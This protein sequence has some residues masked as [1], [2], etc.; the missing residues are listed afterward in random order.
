MNVSLYNEIFKIF[1]PGKIIAGAS[2]PILQNLNHPFFKK[3]IH[4]T[5]QSVLI[6]N[7]STFTYEYVS[8]SILNLTGHP[9]SEF[10]TKGL[11]FGFSLMHADDVHDLQTIVFPE[12][13]RCLSELSYDQKSRF[14]LSYTYRLQKAMGNFVQVLQQSIP[15]SFENGKALLGLVVAIDISAFK[16]DNQ[17]SYRNVLFQEDGTPAVLSQ[18][19]C[20]SDPFSLRELEILQTTANGLSEKQIA[21]T[22]SLSIHTIKT[23][24]KNMLKKAG[25][26]NAAELVRYGMANLLI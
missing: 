8:E 3:L 24:R 21:D 26:K 20:N 14:K 23:H 1:T 19:R 17:V 2:H 7:H 11:N 13:S 10:I 18:S 16:K 4:V 12:Y 9:S 15:L 5:D 6:V 25:V 22:L